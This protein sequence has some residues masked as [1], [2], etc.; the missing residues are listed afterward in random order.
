MTQVKPALLDQ[1]LGYVREVLH[2]E[3]VD[4]TIADAAG[5]TA[6]A[7]AMQTMEETADSVD[8]VKAIVMQGLRPLEG[9]PESATRVAREA[10]QV[11][12]ATLQNLT[13]AAE[14]GDV[15]SMRATASEQAGEDFNYN[16]ADPEGVTA[17]HVAAMHHQGDVARILL[18]NGADPNLADRTGHTALHHTCQTFDENRVDRDVLRRK[19]EADREKCAEVLLSFNADA[20]QLDG[21]RRPPLAYACRNGIEGMIRGLLLNG[22]STDVEG[23]DET[24]SVLDDIA[25]ADLRGRAQEH[26]STYATEKAA[27]EAETAQADGGA[28]AMATDVPP[29]DDM[30]MDMAPDFPGEMDMDLEPMGMDMDPMGMG[31]MMGGGSG[32]GFSRSRRRARRDVKPFTEKVKVV[33]DAPTAAV[34]SE[35]SSDEEDMPVRPIGS[36]LKWGGS[37]DDDSDDDSTPGLTEEERAD[38]EG[39]SDDS[40]ASEISYQ[41]E[42]EYEIDSDEDMHFAASDSDDDGLE[43]DDDPN[44]QHIAQ[45][46]RQESGRRTVKEYGFKPIHRDTLWKMREKGLQD[47]M[48]EFGI[49]KSAAAAVMKNYQWDIQ[50][51]RRAF[52]R[53]NEMPDEFLR[54]NK[55]EYDVSEVIIKGSGETVECLVTMEDTTEWSGLEFCSCKSE[56]GCKFSNEAWRGYFESCIDSGDVIG[57]KC[58]AE[59]CNVLVPE[60]FVE[61]LVDEEHKARYHRFLSESYVKDQTA[62]KTIKFCPAPDCGHA[63]DARKATVDHEG[64]AVSVRCICGYEFCYRCQDEA[65][66]PATC[67]ELQEWNKRFTD[68]V[69]TQQYLNTF[70]KPC[71]TQPMIDEFRKAHP[72]FK[73]HTTGEYTKTHGCGRMIYKD[74]GCNHM[75]A[76]PCGF[77]WCWQCGGPYYG[78]EEQ[79]HDGKTSRMEYHND[80]FNCKNVNQKEIEAGVNEEAKKLDRWKEISDSFATQINAEKLKTKQW[81]D[82]LAMCE[83]M[84]KYDGFGDGNSKHFSEGDCE[85]LKD[86]AQSMFESRRVVKFTYVRPLLESLSVLFESSSVLQTSLSTRP[87]ILRG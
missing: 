11:W 7:Y 51:A 57:L 33:K 19:T 52:R 50:E 9:Q 24:K 78:T 32:A 53:A 81:Q 39:A 36:R 35:S 18:E 21:E 17:L 85:E 45:L 68:D 72:T 69:E 14:Q 40:D 56:A 41:S 83:E 4:A 31:M 66:A 5:Q 87:L 59:H 2:V 79:C 55:L 12:Q 71:P 61:S 67:D 46:C 47:V 6:L 76:C 74:K 48:N 38:M 65:H 58:M 49:P 22:A 8:V 16:S 84:R 13:Q 20:D 10:Y 70:C 42:E 28:Q 29:V 73:F 82:V 80:F 75:W 30:A 54:L 64:K 15:A 77:H 63:M 43:E 86:A 26:A 44:E 1:R 60:S 25:D 62:T 34:L 27:A 3:G 37:D 23:E